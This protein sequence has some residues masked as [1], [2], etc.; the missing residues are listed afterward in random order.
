MAAVGAFY[1][2][3]GAHE[4]Y[5]KLFVR[6]AVLVGVVASLLQLFP[7]GDMQGKMIARYQPITL[8]AMEAC[9]HRT[10]GAPLAILGQP[11][12]QNQRLDNPLM[13]PRAAELPHLPGME[14][15]RERTRS[16]LHR[17]SGRTNSRC[18]ITAIT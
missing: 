3:T 8:A 12:V 11:D 7:T 2:L 15:Q 14:G 13:V 1:L 18:S 5:G 4:N 10:Q 9:S 6:T 16:A 17:T